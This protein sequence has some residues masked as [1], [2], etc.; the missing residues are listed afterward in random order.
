MKRILP[1]LLVF[2]VALG[3]RLGVTALRGF[4]RPP[5]KD[6]WSYAAIAT[7]VAAGEGIWF[8]VRRWDGGVLRPIRL[9]SLRPPLYPVVLGGARALVSDAVPLGRAL[10]GLFG[11]LAVALFYLWAKG[12][13]PGRP[14]LWVALAFAVW[15]S[16]L[17]A[18]GELLTEPL[19]LLLTIGFALALT[20]DRPVVAGIL[21]GLAVLTRPSGLLLL[22]PAW[23]FLLS[24]RKLRIAW[25]TIPVIVLVAPWVIR[26]ASI[27]DRPLL[28]TNM[29][30]TFY[31]GNSGLSLSDPVPGRW[32]L[33][34]K[35]RPDDPPPFGYYGWP[36]LTEAQN[37]RRFL[38]LGL[39]WV[40]EDPG[41]WARLVGWKAVRFLDPDPRSAKEDAGLKKWA[42][43]LSFGPLLALALLGILPMIRW[44][45][46]AILPLGMIAVQLA[47]ALIFFGDARVRLPAVPGFLLLGTAGALS[48]Y[49]RL[50]GSPGASRGP[51]AA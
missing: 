49:V 35:I 5:V 46:L 13:F 42:G 23:L 6:E 17:W 32:H 34:E 29:G 38:A 2:L 36:D 50:R 45:T 33:P 30:V 7:N 11:A 21:L 40:K 39:D 44:R 12:L 43:W 1:V 41:R 16:H 3:L 20:R 22:A 24:G 28:T 9:H 18:S 51:G 27:H 47:I 15:P 25:L 10:S 26:N 19:Y 37:D 31:G 4:D 48:L 8:E 14:A